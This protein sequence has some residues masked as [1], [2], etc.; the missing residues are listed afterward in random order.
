M[1]L[2][3]MFG[4][5]NGQFLDCHQ[6]D[7]TPKT[8]KS[9][10]YCLFLLLPPFKVSLLAEIINQ[11]MMPTS[12]Q[13][14]GCQNFSNPD[15]FHLL[16]WIKI[17]LPKERNE[18]KVRSC[19]VILENYFQWQHTKEA[20]SLCLSLALTFFHKHTHTHIPIHLTQS[21]Q[22]NGFPENVFHSHALFQKLLFPH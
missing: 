12:V 17:S 16:V 18:L 21:K 2:S 11:A 7:P 3:L 15:I 9:F 5:R 1:T 6:K 19:L 8:L 22:T 13:S 10:F 14:E 20:F 4:D